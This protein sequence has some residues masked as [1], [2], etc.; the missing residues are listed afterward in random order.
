[1][2]SKCLNSKFYSIEETKKQCD[3]KT[4]TNVINFLYFKFFSSF[5]KSYVFAFSD[6]ND[7]FRFRHTLSTSLS[8]QNTNKVI[9][10]KKFDDKILL[11]CIFNGFSLQHQMNFDSNRN[12]NMTFYSSFAQHKMR[13]INYIASFL[14]LLLWT[15]CSNRINPIHKKFIVFFIFITITVVF[16]MC[17]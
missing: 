14:L 3:R 9:A 11:W 13:I 16:D 7:F 8:I 1:M 4:R 10:K 5:I 12:W 15:L 6:V 2:K 17:L